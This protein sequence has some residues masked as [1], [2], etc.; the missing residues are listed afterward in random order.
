MSSIYDPAF[1]RKEYKPYWR[2]GEIP[3]SIILGKT[4]N[5]GCFWPGQGGLFFAARPDHYPCDAHPSFSSEEEARA[6]IIAPFVDKLAAREDVRE[7]A[8]VEAAPKR[9]ARAAKAK[10]FEERKAKKM[11]KCEKIFRVLDADG[12]E[13]GRVVRET[14]TGAMIAAASLLGYCKLPDGYSVQVV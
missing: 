7:K 3:G 10:V 5:L 4:R 6:Y 2:A 12:K 14:E 9:E 8:W 11:R 13:I 1:V